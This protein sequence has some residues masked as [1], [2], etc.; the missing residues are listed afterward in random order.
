MQRQPAD[1]GARLFESRRNEQ[2]PRGADP[3]PA[4]EVSLLVARPPQSC[5]GRKRR[6][7]LLQRPPEEEYP[8]LWLRKAEQHKPEETRQGRFQIVTGE[9]T[10]FVWKAQTSIPKP[11]CAR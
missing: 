4:A 7:G 8:A 3:R 2:I 11:R 10:H 5:I 9:I 6:D 1:K